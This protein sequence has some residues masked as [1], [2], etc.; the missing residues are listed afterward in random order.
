MKRLGDPVTLGRVTL[1]NRICLPPMV[2]FNIAQPEGFVSQANVAHYRAMAEGGFGL[3]IQ[4]ATCVSPAGRLHESQL[5]IWSDDQIPGLRE[6]TETVHNQGGK[7][8]VQIHHA[9]IVSCGEDH[10]CPSPY[11]FRGKD[12]E[13]HGR[14]MTLTEIQQVKTEFA[15]AAY[16]AK[17]AGYDGVEI[18]GC[19]GYLLSQFMNRRVN[20]RQDHYGTPMALTLEIVHLIRSVC[21]QDFLVG[22]RLGGF[23]PT[24]AD[25]IDHAKALEAAGIDFL[26]ISYGF[27]GEMEKQAPGNQ[28]LRD[29]IRA[30]G[31]IKANVSV[32][33]FAVNGICTPEE[34][35][36][37]LAETDVD[38]VDIGRS[39]LVDPAWPNKALAGET[40]GRCLHCRVCQWRIDRT[41]CAG[42]LMMEKDK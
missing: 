37:V 2:V 18:H 19:H 9:G 21:G 15:N 20:Q 31:A 24:L 12:G 6:I 34:A 39:A 23:E 4:E 28:A 13:I 1:K 29:V 14:E 35:E 25:A 40:P 22:I 10:P 7:I 32:P 26:D 11:V 3:I 41:K 17:Q 16:R 33:V 38:M 36:L 8:V 5:G 27:E 30:A 42:R